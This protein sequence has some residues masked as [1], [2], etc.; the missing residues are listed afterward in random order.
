[1]LLSHRIDQDDREL[2]NTNPS[3][4]HPPARSA[5]NSTTEAEDTL[6]TVT[7]ESP[8]TS[9]SVADVFLPPFQNSSKA[10]V[11][12]SSEPDTDE[13]SPDSE[14]SES[15]L[16]PK[17]GSGPRLVEVKVEQ[18]DGGSTKF[19]VTST[20]TRA[21]LGKSKVTGENVTGWL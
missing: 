6:S 2:E 5:L 20:P 10:A 1:M 3:Q 8:L 19:P 4:P 17:P 9:T 12:V 11:E 21:N 15:K 7:V 14:S 18:E 16:L 13:A